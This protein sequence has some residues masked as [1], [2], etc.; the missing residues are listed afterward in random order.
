MKKYIYG[1]LAIAAIA[2]ASCSQEEPVT[3]PAG[4]GTVTF[5]AKL[6]SIA[7]RAFAD[8]TTA[9]N[10]DYYV[11][12]AEAA[13][14]AAPVITGTATFDADLTAQV[15]LSL[16]TGKTYDIVFWASSGADCYTYTEADRSITV[17]YGGEANDEAR[18]AF[19]NTVQGLEVKGAINQS[20][21][22]NRPFA[23]VN[24]GTSDLDIAS[25]AG[26][27]LT[28]TGLKM[29]LPTTLNLMDGTV[30]GEEAVAVEFTQTAIPTAETFPV[31]PTTYDYIS[32]NYVLTGAD[33]S[34][35]DLTLTTDHPNRPEIAF[36]SVPVQRNYR[37]NIFGALLTNPANFEVKIDKEFGGNHD[38]E[39][40]GIVFDEAT[41][42]YTISDAGGLATLAEMV[43]GGESLEGMTVLLAA[44]IVLAEP[45]AGIGTF[46]NNGGSAAAKSAPFMGTFDGQNHTVT[47][48][49]STVSDYKTAA[50]FFGYV[51]GGAVIKNLTLKDAAITGTAYT[52]AL[53]GKADKGKSW[54][55]IENVTIDGA[56]VISVP[57]MGS[58]GAYDGGNNVGGL[59][60]IT[61]Y[62][63]DVQGCTVRN[64]SVSGYAKVGGMFGMVCNMN[65]SGDTNHTVYANNSVINTTVAQDLT[66]AYE[67][68]VPTT[69]GQ[70]YG[71]LSGSALPDTNTATDVTTGIGVSTPAALQAI[72][73]AVNAGDNF[74]GKTVLL[75]AD[76]DLKGIAWT[77][78]GNVLAYPSV[79]FNGIFDGRG[80]T[81]SNLTVDDKTPN[82]ACAGL[83][84][85]INGKIRNLTL[86][87]VNVKSTHY[88]GA[89]VGYSSTNVG[90]EI[91]NCH[92]DGGTVTSVPELINGSYDNGDKCGGLIGYTVVGDVIKDCSVKN[93]TVRAYRDLGGLA[94]YSTGIATMTGNHVENV[95]VIQD[96]TNGYSSSPV[97]TYREIVGRFNT[98]D[99]MQENTA[100]NVTLQSVN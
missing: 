48:F 26:F 98:G 15:N 47:G 70:F 83:F 95:T 71:M 16:V 79:S 93:V 1:T 99:P 22:L 49:T 69:I 77:P 44:D 41:K 14:G 53:I 42:T 78:I 7:S 34:I 10:L 58:D 37:T 75:M 17:T 52:G 100:T 57:A 72:A 21:V 12:D 60:G 45:A 96:N 38:T 39:V 76:L 6:P 2:M 92:I 4:D 63:M 88:A 27:D 31:E 9:A 43:N 32:M 46:I 84:G 33:K 68:T 85:S 40:P 54:V 81:I 94:G 64:S 82:Y 59:V 97:T 28:T 91:S 67:A 36:N 87:D 23:Q 61:Q 90:M 18:D 20:V 29:V 11:Y 51:G 56:T 73:A 5:S 24:V 25:A 8:G 74:K 55:T 80:H 66:N 86:K 13:E 50:G 19:F 3:P 89:L 62:G 35:V 30:S 65:Q